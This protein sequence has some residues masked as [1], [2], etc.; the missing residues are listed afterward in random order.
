VLSMSQLLNKSPMEFDESSAISSTS[1]GKYRVLAELGSGGMA[2]VYLAVSQG[3]AGF[4][5]LVVLKVV[6]SDLAAVPELREAFLREARLCARLNHP[7]VIAVNEVEVLE[8]LP[9]IVMEHLQGR[10]LSSILRRV[11]G[12]VPLDVHLR[13]LMESLNGL[14]YAHELTDF[15]GTPLRLVHRDF[16]PQNIF[17]TY[18][19]SVKVLDFGLAQVTRHSSHNASDAV[20]GKLRYMA[21]EQIT[22]AALDRRTDVFAA[23]V[24]LAELITERRFWGDYSDDSIIAQ[25]TSGSIPTP[26]C[27]MPS[28]P[29]E[30][31]RICAKALAYDRMNRYQ[32]IAEMQRDIEAYMAKHSERITTQEVGRRV[33]EW[34]APEREYA[35]QLIESSLLKE[36]YVS[37]SRIAAAPPT[38]STT[39][40]PP[41]TSATLTVRDLPLRSFVPVSA[42]GRATKL[43][44]KRLG[45]AAGTLSLLG[46]VLWLSHGKVPQVSNAAIPSASVPAEPL[47]VTL[48]ILAFPANAFISIDDMSFIEN[49][50]NRKVAADRTWHKLLVEAPGY[51]PHQQRIQY[52]HSLELEVSL[53]AEAPAA[54]APLKPM[55]RAGARRAAVLAHPPPL[56]H[57]TKGSCSPPYT[58]DERGVKHFRPECL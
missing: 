13:I 33:A 12:K 7:N 9:V 42:Y 51:K 35:Q 52:S 21:P 45:I 8:G 40:S 2:R 49:P 56:T 17:V 26:R 55:P 3:L 38:D 30:L 16:T 15:D 6:R 23:G 31:E 57:S 54:Q 19:G 48:R 1:T 28:C 11:L 27:T 34:F 47:S 44:L 41:P 10:S 53:E 58:Y 36:T 5:K 29:P 14:H 4:S 39:R 20:Q 18:D 50:Y 37:W 25:L 24:L 22:T 43:W 32:T 46:G